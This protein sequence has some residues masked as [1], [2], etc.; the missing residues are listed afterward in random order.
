MTYV[1]KDKIMKITKKTDNA[2][3]RAANLLKTQMAKQ[4]KSVF[5]TALK[6]IEIRFGRNFDGFESIRSEILRMGNE[7]IRQSE[8]VIDNGYNVE[9]V[10]EVLT[11]NFSGT[12]KATGGSDGKQES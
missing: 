11:I 8:V 5:I 12:G 6:C 7:A 10:P 9:I 1:I 2:S 3:L 4:I